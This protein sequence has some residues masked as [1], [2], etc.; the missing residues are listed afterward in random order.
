[1]KYLALL[2][3]LIISSPCFA[4]S[5][6]NIAVGIVSVDMDRS[7][8]EIS[9]ENIKVYLNNEGKPKASLRFEVVY[10]SSKT[11]N[12]LYIWA[13]NASSFRERLLAISEGELAPTEF[14][15]TI[16]FGVDQGMV[17][18]TE[19]NN[20]KY[21]HILTAE[22]VFLFPEEYIPEIIALLDTLE[23][24]AIPKK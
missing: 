2:A 7:G 16:K 21:V 24:A 1:M 5:A 11:V 22:G 4:G 23:K 18:P 3:F 10:P 8:S 13:E 15:K 20:K 17:R 19:V 9:R 12:K 14:L 6:T